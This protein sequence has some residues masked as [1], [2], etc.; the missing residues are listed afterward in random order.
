LR[1]MRDTILQS[2][3]Q[4]Q[5]YGVPTHGLQEFSD[6][7]RG[8]NGLMAQVHEQQEMLRSLSLTDPLTGLGNRRA[9]NL[10]LER[11]WNRALRQREEF[12]LLM[13]DIDHFKRFNDT[14]GHQAGD[15]CIE[16]VSRVIGEAVTRSAD[17]ACRYGGEEFAV[18]LP[19]TD[20][21]GALAVAEKIMA[22]VRQL[23]IPHTGSPDQGQVTLSIGVTACRPQAQI[24]DTCPV[25]CADRALY[26]AKARGRNCVVGGPME[27]PVHCPHHRGEQPN[28]PESPG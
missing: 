27:L 4:Q 21:A 5:H 18:I 15:R 2:L 20:S 25:E 28:F 13:I 19:D 17:S 14:Y 1:R 24:H 11:E 16:R 7:A 23:A 22:G 3:A 12:A 10:A 26:A 6:L 8:F 9:F